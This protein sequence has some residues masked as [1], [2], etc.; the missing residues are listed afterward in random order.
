MESPASP[1]YLLP[2][3]FEFFQGLIRKISLVWKKLRFYFILKKAS[4]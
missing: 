2:A 4:E 3:E 1:S